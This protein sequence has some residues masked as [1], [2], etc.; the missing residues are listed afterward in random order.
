M[1]N[2]DERRRTLRWMSAQRGINGVLEDLGSVCNDIAED[3]HNNDN[4]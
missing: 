1:L 2:N 4:N 3:K